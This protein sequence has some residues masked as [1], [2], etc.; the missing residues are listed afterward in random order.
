MAGFMDM[1]RYDTCYQDYQAFQ[2]NNYYDRHMDLNTVIR[3]N[4]DPLKLSSSG[5][6]PT[7]FGPIR[8]KLVTQESVLTKQLGQSKSDCP[9]CDVNYLPDSL[10]PAADASSSSS[11]Q[12]CQITDLEPLYTKERKSCN[13]LE[14]TDTSRTWM[15]PGEYQSGY[16][17]PYFG[18]NG[19]LQ[20][21]M[22]PYDP[23]LDV[24]NQAFGGC[25]SNYGTYGGG[26]DLQPYSL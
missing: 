8:G 5:V 3:P 2:D 6:Y 21:L 14:E 24:G 22:A 1:T 26:R 13:G 15:L 9:G 20:T 19:N 7:T 17:G 23:N 10:F 25:R 18:V 12:K 16:S 4:V 11:K